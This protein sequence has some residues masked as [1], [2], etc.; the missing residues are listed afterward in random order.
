MILIDHEL[1]CSVRS[2]TGP[3]EDDS[4]GARAL[5]IR[6]RATLWRKGGE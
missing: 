4:R 2:H 6:R 5:I 3:S 1:P